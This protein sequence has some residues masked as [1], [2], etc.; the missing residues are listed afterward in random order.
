MSSILTG[1]TKDKMKKENWDVKVWGYQEL[2]EHFMFVRINR[3]AATAHHLVSFVD[4]AAHTVKPPTAMT[5]LTIVVND[6]HPHEVVES[7]R[8]FDEDDAR[9]ILAY[10]DEH[11]IGEEFGRV[12]VQCTAGIS[13]STATA[14]AMLVHAGFTYHEAFEKIQAVRPPMHPN[15]WMIEVFD[16]VMGKGGSFL[17]YYKDWYKTQAMNP[18]TAFGWVPAEKH[19]HF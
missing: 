16:R 7:K 5:Q 1:A 4:E 9:R 8:L 12:I 11:K 14:L 15:V 6:I 18:I 17:A 2:Q 3:D 13:R 19:Y 10:V